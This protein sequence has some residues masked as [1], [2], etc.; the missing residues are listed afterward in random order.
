MRDKLV[1]KKISDYKREFI[2]RTKWDL[3]KDMDSKLEKFII[4]KAHGSLHNRDRKS[5]YKETV[6]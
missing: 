4:Q 6:F 3:L 5:F 2:R 1:P